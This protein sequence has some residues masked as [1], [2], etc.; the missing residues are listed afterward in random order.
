MS[1]EY[2]K[3]PLNVRNTVLNAKNP[4]ANGMDF[5]SPSYAS[6]F[7]FEK[8]KP[9]SENGKQLLFITAKARPENAKIIPPEIKVTDGRKAVSQSKVYRK[10]V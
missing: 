10:K 8:F 7:Q 2:S 6:R 3:V 9:N 5:T 4:M 1:V